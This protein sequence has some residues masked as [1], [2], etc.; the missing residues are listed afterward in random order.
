MQALIGQ[1]L[2][3]RDE[4]LERC[5][6]S[7]LQKQLDLILALAAQNCHAVRYLYIVHIAENAVHQTPVRK[8]Q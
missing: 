1:A 5:Q 6:W 7:R 2:Q 3:R 8:Y 4:Y